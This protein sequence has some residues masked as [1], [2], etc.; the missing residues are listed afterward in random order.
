MRRFLDATKQAQRFARARPERVS[1]RSLRKEFAELTTPD[2]C[3]RRWVGMAIVY[4]LLCIVLFAIEGFPARPARGTICRVTSLV[5][6]VTTSFLMVLLVFR[7]LD[8][9]R[10]IRGYIRRLRRT[11]FP[12]G[13]AGGGTQEGPSETGCEKAFESVLPPA[14]RAA[15]MVYQPFI[16]LSIMIVARSTIFD[17]WTWPF[18]VVIAMTGC[19]IVSLAAA[20]ALRLDARRLKERILDHLGHREIELPD[21]NRKRKLQSLL[22]RI[23]EAHAPP[24]GPWF[25]GTAI[26]SLLL[27]LGSV[28]TVN[29]VDFILNQ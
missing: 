25:Q 21:G 29:L 8:A 20:F 11:L 14:A 24:F 12:D 3:R 1:L 19:F 27:P 28:G 26:Q 23:R 17:R 18:N 7:V 6:A 5:V 13:S 15:R 10:M 4:F 2:A 9:T 22:H 16:V